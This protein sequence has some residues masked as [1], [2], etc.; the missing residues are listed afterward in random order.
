MS[1]VEQTEQGTYQ[2]WT[3]G[4]LGEILVVDRARGEL[5]DVEELAE[6][7]E[8]WMGQI[9]SL[10]VKLLPE[11]GPNGERYKLLGGGRR[12][13]AFAL[14]LKEKGQDYTLGLRVYPEHL[15]E[16]QEKSIEL[17]E[18]EMRLALTWQDKAKLTQR[19]HK[20]HLGEYGDPKHRHGEEKE[21]AWTVEKTADL[22]STSERTVKRQ[23]RMA[24]ALEQIPEL[25][26]CK[27]ADEA[28]NLLAHVIEN[29]A[30]QEM[31]RR[32][33][34]A[35]PQGTLDEVRK[36][37]TEAYKVG[38]SFEYL[39]S[40][41]DNC[42]DFIDLDPDYAID[43]KALGAHNSKASKRIEAL[44]KGTY[45]QVGKEGYDL[46]LASLFEECHRILK[47]TGWL[48]CWY[49][50]DPWHQTVYEQLRG[51]GFLVKGLPALW[52]KG[53]SEGKGSACPDTDLGRT[54]EPFFYAR[55]A[56]AVIRRRARADSFI[57]PTPAGKERIHSAQKSLPLMEDILKTLA[58]PGAQV[59]VPFAGSGTS[60]LAAYNVGM[61]GEGCD[62]SQEYKDRFIVRLQTWEPKSSE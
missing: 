13:A 42:A 58:M 3:T 19:I 56:S 46:Y 30:T 36:L 38:D 44:R 48:I 29:L 2:Q 35:A 43:F 1:T 41:P 61:V 49:A 21:Q 15:T 27:S 22:L 33:E 59:I 8:S 57:Y 9:Q 50:M 20:L 7:L 51:A 40:L 62:L 37:I 53:T 45:E 16:F 55:K 26:K 34:A 25:Q 10:A 6:S 24:D 54:Y 17:M 23:L 28:E 5:G 18:N 39:E 11:P 52:I 60:I 14:L 47:P 31:A 4:K 32:A 12:C